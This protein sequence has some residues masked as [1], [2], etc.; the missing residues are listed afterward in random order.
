MTPLSDDDRKKVY[1][2]LMRYLSNKQETV[3]GI[4][5]PDLLE[6]VIAADTW[7]DQQAANYNSSLPLAFRSNATQSQKA[8]LLS[9]VILARYDPALLSNILGN[10]T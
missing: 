9:A 10:V 7:A 6:A 8:L 4:L 5:K 3:S 1:R 2:G